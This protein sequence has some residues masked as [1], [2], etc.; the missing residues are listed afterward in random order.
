M[1]SLLTASSGLLKIKSV[2]KKQ[3]NLSQSKRNMSPESAKTSK[4]PTEQSKETKP[5]IAYLT[6]RRR[7]DSEFVT[8]EYLKHEID[9][10][11]S[12]NDSEKHSHEEGWLVQELTRL[13]AFEFLQRQFRT[14]VD[15]YRVQPQFEESLAQHITMTYENSLTAS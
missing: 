11:L 5:T 1:A 14:K 6:R 4:Y 2:K 9:S 3:G 10:S 12:T 7:G 15:L 8:T 13:N